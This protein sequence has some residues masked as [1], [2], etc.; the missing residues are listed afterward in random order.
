MVG[1]WTVLALVVSGCALAVDWSA[2]EHGKAGEDAKE[3]VDGGGDGPLADH[4]SPMFGG[5]TDSGFA[6]D[7]G[8][9]ADGAPPPVGDSSTSTDSAVVPM[10]ATDPSLA[11]VNPSQLGFSCVGGATPLQTFAN[12]ACTQGPTQ[13]GAVTY[14]CSGNYCGYQGSPGD[15]QD[16]TS[17]YLQ[18]CPAVM[19]Q[20]EIDPAVDD[21]G[22][23]FCDDYGGCVSDCE[24]NSPLPP[25]SSVPLCENQCNGSYSSTAALE[26]RL[27]IGCLVNYCDVVCSWN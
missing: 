2:L 4:V 11:C 24:Y 7:A 17:C 27:V 21:G 10:C 25:S 5:K 18:N 12:L 1:G 9:D 14:C 22:T 8:H 15:T 23:P 16:C 19:C 13:P 26:G 6:T 3:P 20:C